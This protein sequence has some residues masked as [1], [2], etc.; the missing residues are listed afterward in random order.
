MY[1]ASYNSVRLCSISRDL[2]SLDGPPVLLSREDDNSSQWEA[3]FDLRI[4]GWLPGSS[5]TS[6][7]DNVQGGIG[8]GL[9]AYVTYL[10]STSSIPCIWSMGAVCGSR[11]NLIYTVQAPEQVVTINRVK[12]IPS[13]SPNY[14]SL[15]PCINYFKSISRDL[16]YP[17][18]Y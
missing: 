7:S 3:T 6:Q 17:S 15:F 13:L 4:P 10:E 8:Y 1:G 14:P 11:C 5:D 12:E 9:F 16:S 2:V 18:T